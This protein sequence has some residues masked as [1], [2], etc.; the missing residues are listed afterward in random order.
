MKKL[1]LQ[2]FS[3]LAI[4]LAFQSCSKTKTYAEML[5][6]EKDAINT[7]IAKNKIKVISKDQFEAQNKTTGKNEY[8]AF[9]EDGVYMNIEVKG[10][11]L[12]QNN[13]VIL[14]RFLEFDIVSNDTTIT[15]FFD[16][17]SVDQFRYTRTD[18]SKGN[19][20]ATYG[21]FFQEQNQK[22]YMLS[23]YGSAVPSGWLKA[24]R[25]VGHNS[26]VK[27]IV[28]SKMGHKTAQQNVTPYFYEIQYTI[29]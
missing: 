20:V 11:R 23:Y 29:F 8:V 26:K 7:Y 10:D 13:D 15:N 18:D 5:S 9:P 28:P 6:D 17:T 3:L 16:N 12:A 1:T 4:G 24:L 14:A 2:L 25:Y 21:Q 27:M 22:A 19:I